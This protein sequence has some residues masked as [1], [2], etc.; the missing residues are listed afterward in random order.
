MPLRDAL[1]TFSPAG[2][3]PEPIMEEMSQRCGESVWLE[4]EGGHR[5][6]FL[7]DGRDFDAG[8]FTLESKVWDYDEC[9]ICGGR[10][11]SM[12]LCHVTMPGQPNILLC[13]SCYKHHIPTKRPTMQIIARNGAD[14]IREHDRILKRLLAQRAHE[15]QSQHGFRKLFTR[16]K[17]EFW[18][19]RETSRE[20]RRI[21]R[22]GSSQRI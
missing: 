17:I 2:S 12:T 7:Y 21:L 3:A 10:I 4:A 15:W 6:L 16:I 18:A 5:V 11:P 1:T 8:R 14:Q 19:W 13:V 22:S 9:G 20:Q